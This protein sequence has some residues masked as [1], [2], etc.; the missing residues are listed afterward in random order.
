MMLIISRIYSFLTKTMGLFLMKCSDQTSYITDDLG[1]DFKEYLNSENYK[2]IRAEF[3]KDFDEDSLSEFKTLESR[4]KNVPNRKDIT[5]KKG[6]SLKWFFYENP[7]DV[8]RTSLE[9]DVNLR[10]FLTRL[11]CFWKYP[12]MDIED[13]VF[14]Y[15]HGLVFLSN[16][17]K[18]YINA[19]DFL[20]IG[21]FHGDSII[22]LNEYG[23]KTIHGFDISKI[24]LGKTLENLKKAKIGVDNIILNCSYVGAKSSLGVVVRDTGMSNLQPTADEDSTGQ[25]GYQ[26]ETISIDDYC[27]NLPNAIKLIKADVEGA[28]KEVI[29]GSEKVISSNRPVLLLAVYHNPKEFFEVKN[30]IQSW[31]LNYKFMLKKLTHR[32]MR[33][34]AHIETFLI[35]FPEEL[36]I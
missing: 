2:V 7:L 11:Y 13:S 21:T 31:N 3:I 33:N 22:A 17:V 28:L 20:D 18:E 16:R 10:R 24:S 14:Y 29:I 34:A 32:R 19:N 26:I 30:L 8:N 15:K 12:L 1:G 35:C 6:Y 9:G 4:F 36:D 25:N 27:S 5:L 23:F